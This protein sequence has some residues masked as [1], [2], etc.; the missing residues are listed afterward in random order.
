CS[1]AASAG[2]RTRSRSG[3]TA[4]SSTTR[5]GTTGHTPALATGSPSKA[6]TRSKGSP[7]KKALSRDGEKRACSGLELR[8][9]LEVAVVTLGG[10]RADL[11]RPIAPF[12]LL[13]PGRAVDD[14]RRVDLVDREVFLHLRVVGLF[15]PVA[16]YPAHSRHLP[17]H[18]HVFGVVDAVEFGLV[19]G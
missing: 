2:R 4:A 1:S 3:T 7:H 10:V 18:R 16:L 13:L 19:L 8:D 15:Q 14:L 12:P 11:G 9:L 17:Q 6:T 5:C